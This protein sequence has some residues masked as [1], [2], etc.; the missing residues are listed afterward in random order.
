MNGMP[1]PELRKMLR[2]TFGV[3][4]PEKP[5]EPAALPIHDEPKKTSRGIGNVMLS[6][7]A[8]RI[9]APNMPSVPMKPP[10]ATQN[11]QGTA[12]GMSMQGPWGQPE[13]NK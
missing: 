9:Y 5:K 2:E 7:E 1:S 13:E 10:N 3:K 11:A 12:P 6:A 4:K 8:Q